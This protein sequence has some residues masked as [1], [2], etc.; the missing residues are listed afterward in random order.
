LLKDYVLVFLA[1]TRRNQRIPPRRNSPKVWRRSQIV[2]RK[3]EERELIFVTSW[4]IRKEEEVAQKEDGRPRDQWGQPSVLRGPS[5]DCIWQ[6]ILGEE[7]LAC[8]V[9]PQDWEELSEEPT[10]EDDEEPVVPVEG[11]EGHRRASPKRY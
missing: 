1:W 10:Q 6:R 3:R 11:P 9:S 2:Q 4:R 7:S 8:K 5:S